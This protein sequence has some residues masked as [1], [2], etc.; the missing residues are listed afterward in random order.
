MYFFTGEACPSEHIAQRY[1]SNG[2]CAECN[3]PTNE[4]FQPGANDA[5]TFETFHKRQRVYT[6]IEERLK[7][8]RTIFDE[9]R[10]QGFV[11]SVRQVFYQFVSRTWEVNDKNA[12]T[13]IGDTIKKGRLEGVLDWDM[14]E[15]RSRTLHDVD[16]WSSPAEYVRAAGY[17]YSL[18][19]WQW[20]DHAPL[21]LIEKDALIGV[22]ENVCKE[23]R[24]PYMGLHGFNSTS[25]NRVVS[26]RLKQAIEQDRK[27]IVFHLGDHDPSGLS[28]TE[29]L[30]K[31]LALMARQPVEVVR[32]A[33]NS[34]QGPVDQIKKYKPP[35]NMLKDEDEIKDTRYPK[36]LAEYGPEMWELDAL[37]PRV[38]CEL[39]R[40]AT[41]RIIGLN[42][43]ERAIDREQTGQD[44]IAKIAKHKSLRTL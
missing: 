30:R 21:V 2:N 44:A 36:Y 25:M 37:E 14:I 32:L 29:A 7:K 16:H 3:R 43:W 1:V 42:D 4:R 10:D 27:P 19:Y 34:D 15:D 17:G 33:L 24:L 22:I 41:D 38:I 40:K 26:E 13:R 18:D 11:L 39:I 23:L 12:Y 31:T 9:Y 6:H 5:G 35:P 8:I 28:A 20:Q